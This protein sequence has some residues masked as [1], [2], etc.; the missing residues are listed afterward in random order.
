VDFKDYY[1]ILGVD[2]DADKKAIKT[3]YRKLARKYHPDVSEKHDAETRFK[4]M[5]EAY[6]VLKN[7]AK[8]A[9]YDEIRKY[10][11]HGQE[12]RPPPGWQASGGFQQAGG[13][14][15][16]DY[17]DFFETLFGAAGSVRPS[18]QAGGFRQR[19]RDI[20]LEMPVMLED[21]VKGYSDTIS[22]NM[23]HY[24]IGGQRVE[25]ISKKLKVKIPA[26][27]SEGETLRLEGQ[28]GPGIGN[29]SPGDLYLKIRLVPHPMFDVEGHN[30]TITVPL[31]P[32]EAALGTT[33]T[34][35]TL[36]GNI[37][38][39]IP[40][41]SQSGRRMRIR[42]KGLATRTGRGDLYAIIRI[43]IPELG[44][45]ENSKLW[46]ELAEKTGFNPRSSWENVS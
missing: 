31:A 23:P 41:D 25:D 8:R 12:F 37:K 26:G 17:S 15:Q 28:G 2:P 16:G 33:V 30:L 35:P 7:Q 40:P 9:E 19:G 1:K 27:I 32:W 14:D 38:L 43:V 34:V 29:G 46:S 6:N 20:E 36:H 21:T 13:F 22:Y 3:A 11:Q 45:Q 42:G 5:T 18:R 39:K 10:G 24:D 44:N 4:E